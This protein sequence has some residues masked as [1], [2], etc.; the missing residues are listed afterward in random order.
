MASG[1]NTQGQG[2]TWAPPKGARMN[3]CLSELE[4]W[5]TDRGDAGPAEADVPLPLSWWELCSLPSIWSP[6]FQTPLSARGMKQRAEPPR[7][8]LPCLVLHTLPRVCS[9][10]SR[11]GDLCQMGRGPRPSLRVCLLCLC[12]RPC[13]RQAGPGATSVLLISFAGNSCPFQFFPFSLSASASPLSQA[14]LAFSA[15]F[16]KMLD[17]FFCLY[18]V[19]CDLPG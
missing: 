3:P 12:A 13:L 4:N 15:F 6:H 7:P 19:Q 8:P 9:P 18:L 10:Q 11:R 14:P 5:L 2:S 1:L 16:S 17:F